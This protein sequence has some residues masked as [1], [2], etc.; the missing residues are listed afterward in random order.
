[1]MTT[2]CIQIKSNTNR[3]R[4][5]C[6][7]EANGSDDSGAVVFVTALSYGY[8]DLDVSKYPLI[9]HDIL[10]PEATTLGQAEAKGEEDTF[11]L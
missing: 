8:D 10:L 11:L 7:G 1:M 4:F 6:E 2:S 3:D 5:Q 9:Q